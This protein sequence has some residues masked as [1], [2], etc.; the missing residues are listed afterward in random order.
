MTNE[1]VL[2]GVIYV[3][4]DAIPQVIKGDIKI[5]TIDCLEEKWKNEL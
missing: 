4:K 1:I 2:N 3:R 5:A